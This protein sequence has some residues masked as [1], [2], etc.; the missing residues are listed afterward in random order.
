MSGFGVLATVRLGLRP[1]AA[2]GGE[3]RPQAVGFEARQ[4]ACKVRPI[5]D[6]GISPTVHSRFSET[7]TS[8]NI[9]KTEFREMVVVGLFK[10]WRND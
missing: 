3:F 4:V 10:R 9:F 1:V 6:V 8:G 7:E 5:L 2:C